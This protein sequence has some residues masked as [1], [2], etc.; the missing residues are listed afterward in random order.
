MWNISHASGTSGES[1]EAS[2]NSE[3][4]FRTFGSAYSAAM[5][6]GFG[7]RSIASS[8]ASLRFALS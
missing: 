8:A 7:S 1:R 2:F 5:R 3:V 6:A 4:K